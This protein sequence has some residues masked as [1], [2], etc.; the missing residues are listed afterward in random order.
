MNERGVAEGRAT[1]ERHESG[2]RIVDRR[3]RGRRRLLGSIVLDR[4][5][6]VARRVARALLW[7]AL[8]LV[9]LQIQAGASVHSFLPPLDVSAVFLTFFILQLGW[10]EGALSAFA[11][12]YLNVLFHGPPGLGSFL[13]VLIWTA[14]YLSLP[15]QLPVHWLAI[16]FL[17]GAISLLYQAGI[18]GGELLIGQGA[19]PSTKTWVALATQAGWTAVWAPV[20]HL[21]LRR[22]DRALAGRERRPGR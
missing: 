6:S 16:A 15:R 12:G 11:V 20:L 7:A 4:R 13:G 8:A 19:P 5:Q 2:L 1:P 18:V 17:S 22:I 10:V 14:G 21:G 3:L 9:L